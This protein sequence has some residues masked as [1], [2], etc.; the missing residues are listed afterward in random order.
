M[1][2]KFQYTLTEKWSIDG[3]LRL[4]HWSISQAHRNEF[5]RDT[6]GPL[7]SLAYSDREDSFVGG[8]FGITYQ[9]SA[10]TNTSLRVFRG[11]RLPTINE[12]YRPFRVGNDITE[13]NPFLKPEILQGSELN[14]KQK[15]RGPLELSVSVF[16]YAWEEVV[17]MCT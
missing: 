6:G 14:W 3:S 5:D 11:F 17:A 2:G 13:A 7:Q 16:Y 12:L 8:D 1:Y 10:Y 4:D 9:Y 15:F